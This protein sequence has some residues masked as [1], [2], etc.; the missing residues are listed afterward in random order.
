MNLKD[1]APVP[2][3]AGFFSS[4]LSVFGQHSVDWQQHVAKAAYISCDRPCT[5]GRLCA[6]SVWAGHQVTDNRLAASPALTRLPLPA[7][8][9]SLSSPARPS[10]L[11]VLT[12][13]SM[14]TGTNPASV[15]THE[16]M[17][18][19]SMPNRLKPPAHTGAAERRTQKKN[20]WTKIT[21]TRNR[22]GFTAVP[23]WRNHPERW[24]PVGDSNPCTHRERV[25]S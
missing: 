20:A 3:A 24:R 11:S 16:S 9:S 2:A 1:P 25:M 6:Y 5:Y 17:T 21:G 23:G 18:R 14:R 22:T 8:F 12:R 19:S 4:R 10:H 15:G 13:L 7:R